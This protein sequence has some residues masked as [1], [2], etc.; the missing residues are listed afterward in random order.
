M[1]HILR[2][3]DSTARDP[4]PIHQV[5]RAGPLGALPDPSGGHPQPREGE[6]DF[7][8]ED[9]LGDLP[10]ENPQAVPVSVD[11]FVEVVTHGAPRWNGTTY[12]LVGGTPTRIV[13]AYPA[14]V[15]VLVSNIGLTTIM[16]S[17]TE[18]VSLVS[19]FS[20]LPGTSIV[21]PTRADIWA[22][23]TANAAYSVAILQTFMDG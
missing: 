17:P 23:T 3:A 2:P 4:E 5:N 16:L 12:N 10:G 13:N 14:R 1:P 11:G 18:A 8:P 9:L 7:E 21:I 6:V 19:A 22:D 15:D 20:L